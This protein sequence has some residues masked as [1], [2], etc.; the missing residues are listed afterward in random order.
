MSRGTSGRRGLKANLPH[1]LFVNTV[2]RGLELSNTIVEIGRH[3][4]EFGHLVSKLVPA[5]KAVGY[6]AGIVAKWTITSR[7]RVFIA[8]LAINDA[9]SF[10]FLLKL[11]GETCV[12]TKGSVD[13]G[14]TTQLIAFVFILS[15]LEGCEKLFDERGGLIE[16]FITI[17]GDENVKLFIL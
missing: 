15:L 1:K 11:S 3:L 17:S 12:V 16:R 7:M 10:L 4:L 13:L 8:D 14:Q 5:I 9:H 2:K 6:I